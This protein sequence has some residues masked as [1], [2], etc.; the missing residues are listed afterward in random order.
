MQDIAH[1]FFAIAGM[2]SSGLIRTENG[3]GTLSGVFL[4]ND[5][6]IYCFGR[7]IKE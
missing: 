3:R 1:I 7:S 6:D 2:N 4:I 5:R